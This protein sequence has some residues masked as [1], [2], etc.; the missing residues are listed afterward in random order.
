MTASALVDGCVAPWARLLLAHGAGAPMDSEFMNAIARD[1]SRL[2]I[3]V[4]RFEFPYMAQRREGGSRRPPNKQEVLLDTWQSVIDAYSSDPLPLFIGGKSM[5]GRIATLWAA[6]RPIGPCRGL[7]C[8]GY[9]FHPAGKPESLRIA[10]LPDLPLPALIVQGTRDKLGSQEEIASYALG[11]QVTC[12][13]I[14]TG[15]HD[16]APLKRSG[17]THEQAI[18]EAAGAI[19]AFMAKQL[20]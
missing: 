20:K 19:A 5:G 16:L 3:E 13:W 9:P 1:C 2:G 12:H 8:L 6:G 18:T 4:V 7:V 11:A 14:A 15:N 17:A 10:H